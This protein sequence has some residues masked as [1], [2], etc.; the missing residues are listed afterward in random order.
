[1]AEGRQEYTD[2]QR[3]THHEHHVRT[4]TDELSHAE[5]LQRQQTHIRIL[6][7]ALV[8]LLVG[9]AYAAAFDL[10]SAPEWIVLGAIV[11]T[12]AGMAIAVHSR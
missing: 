5:K 9:V 7:G 2:P 1:M 4:P 12:V 6:T 3:R 10:D 11:A 8:L